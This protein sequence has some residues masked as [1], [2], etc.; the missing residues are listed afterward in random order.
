MKFFILIL[1]LIVPLTPCSGQELNLNDLEKI[2]KAER[3]ARL[4][5]KA[6]SKEKKKFLSN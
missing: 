3:K 6:L 4:K 1:I 2:T 5:S